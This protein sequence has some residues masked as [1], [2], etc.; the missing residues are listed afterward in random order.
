[1]HIYEYIYIYIYIYIG[2]CA[3]QEG[4]VE[5]VPARVLDIPGRSQLLGLYI[6]SAPRRITRRIIQVR[7]LPIGTDINFGTKYFAET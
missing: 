1:M 6:A 5:G 3:Y 7:A 4:E 2:D